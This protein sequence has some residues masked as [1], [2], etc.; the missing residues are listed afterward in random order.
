MQTT[1]QYL[2]SLALKAMYFYISS[3]QPELFCVLSKSIAQSLGC[4]PKMQ[5]VKLKSAVAG[6]VT[7]PLTPKVEPVRSRPLLATRCKIS[8]HRRDVGLLGSEG[9]SY[10]RQNIVLSTLQAPAALG[11]RGPKARR[12]GGTP[13]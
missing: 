10:V 8:L 11:K 5:G 13:P 12:V 9:T 6:K 3:L 2:R 1:P 4:A 7:R